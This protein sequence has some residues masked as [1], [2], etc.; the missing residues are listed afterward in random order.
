MRILDQLIEWKRRNVEALLEAFSDLPGVGGVPRAPGTTMGAWH[1]IIVAVDPVVAPVGRDDLVDALRQRGVK[2]RIPSTRP[3][4]RT[5]IFTGG[6]PRSWL[7]YDDEVRQRAF[8]LDPAS[9][10]MCER[11]D[12]MWLSLPGT[13]FND[14]AGALVPAYVEAIHDV[15]AAVRP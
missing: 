11:L 5:S 2:A 7:R 10:P 14:E 8:S 1:D 6:L 12:A 3:L 4:H 13:F 15:V 9:F